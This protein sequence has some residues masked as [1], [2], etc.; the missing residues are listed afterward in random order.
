MRRSRAA[1]AKPSSSTPRRNTVM[2]VS[3]SMIRSEL[4]TMSCGEGPLDRQRCGATLLVDGGAPSN[5]RGNSRTGLE[6]QAAMIMATVLVLYY[7]TYGHVETKAEA[8]GA[9]GRRRGRA[10]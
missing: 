2:P 6:T 9:G 7:R 8:G 5:R 10:G 1:A 3:L 4:E